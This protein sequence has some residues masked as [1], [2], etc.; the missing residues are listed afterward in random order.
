LKSNKIVARSSAEEQEIHR[1]LKYDP[2]TGKFTWKYVT[3]LTYGDICFNRQFALKSIEHTSC[4]YLGMYILGRRIQAHRIAWF[5]SYGEWPD[6]PIDHINRNKS[7][8]ALTNLR[9]VTLSVNQ[10][11]S[12]KN[13][14]NTS[15]ATGV[16]WH[17]PNRKWLASMRLLGKY[18]H[19]GYFEEFSDALHARKT[20][21]HANGFTMSHGQP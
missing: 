16:R 5:I 6:L 7:D 4:P 13:T 17:K 18:K 1:K 2:I 11:N 12:T 9:A 10:R 15:G 20:A 8:N 3:P 19:L 21:E 14:K